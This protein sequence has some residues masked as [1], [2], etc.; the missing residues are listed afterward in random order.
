M[1]FVD[2]NGS[3]P[4][5]LA[6]VPLIERLVASSVTAPLTERLPPVTCFPSSPS[7]CIHYRTRHNF[8]F[9]TG[10]T[11]SRQ[12]NFSEN[13]KRPEDSLCVSITHLPFGLF[14]FFLNARYFCSLRKFRISSR[15]P[16]ISL[17]SQVYS[18]SPGSMLVWA[19]VVR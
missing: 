15:M 1:N 16:S 5:S 3:A 11:V 18:S 12:R 19:L 14:C 2:G 4:N 7:V 6:T 17:M 10:S 8:I 9:F 13:R